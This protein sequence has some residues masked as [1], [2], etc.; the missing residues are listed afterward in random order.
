MSLV[1]A[2]LESLL[3]LCDARNM[4]KQQVRLQKDTN[5]YDTITISSRKALEIL[6]ATTGTLSTWKA[7]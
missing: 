6:F 5:G 3:E 7:R 2:T 4:Y 1:I